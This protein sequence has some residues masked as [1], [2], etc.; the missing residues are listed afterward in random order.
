MLMK[1]PQRIMLWWDFDEE[2]PMVQLRSA[3][4]DLLEVF[5]LCFLD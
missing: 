3:K 5:G 1:K 4:L 2:F